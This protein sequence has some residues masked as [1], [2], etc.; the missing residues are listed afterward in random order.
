VFKKA[1]MLIALSVSVANFSG[2][3]FLAAGAAGAGTV[4]WLSDKVTQEVN[5]PIDRV[6]RSTRSVLGDMNASIFKETKAPDVT[7]IL[8]KDLKDKQIWVD[9]H[10]IDKNNTSI[11]VRVGYL[12]GEKDAQKILT[13]IVNRS[14]SIL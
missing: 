3:I 1:L 10:P 6:T 12:N 8:A 13:R 11:S 4:K 5:S 2:C 14:D 9:I 7:Q